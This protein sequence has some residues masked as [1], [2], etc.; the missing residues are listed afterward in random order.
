MTVKGQVRHAFPAY[1]V[2][3]FGVDVTED[4]LAVEVQ[5]NSGRAPNGCSITLAN[6]LDKYIFTTND[7]KALFGTPDVTEAIDRLS[8]IKQVGIDK[9]AVES[10]QRLSDEQSIH[11][12][13][14]EGTSVIQPEIKR[15]VINA[16]VKEKFI[17]VEQE[18][19][20]D[21]A[22][23]S[24]K[25]LIGDAPRYPFQA[26]DPIF[27]ANDPIRVFFKDPF[28]PRRWY[29]AFAGFISDFDDSVD[30]NNQATLTVSGEGPTKVFRY[31]RITTNPGIIDINA[32]AQAKLDAVFRS[33][34]VSGFKKLTLP[35]LLFAITFGNDP[36]NEFGGSFTVERASAE[37]T[38]VQAH[39]LR[40]VGNFN[41][42]RS[43]VVE[44]GNT[45]AGGATD[46]VSIPGNINTFSVGSLGEYQAII[47]HEV[48]ETDLTEMVGN[49]PKAE[50][51]ATLA[52]R[53]V[54]RRQ[55]ADGSPGEADPIA[56][57]EAIGKNPQ[58]YPVDGGRLIIL[59]PA[60]FQ[61]E[62]NREVLLKDII[63]AAP[64]QTEFKSRLGIIYDTIER[65]EF[66][67][68]ESPK[69][70]LICEFPLYDFDPQDFELEGTFEHIDTS[71]NPPV[72]N[73]NIRRG[74]F[75]NKLIVN[76]RD[77][78]DFSKGVTD[79]KVR[80]QV[81]AGHKLFQ[82]YS[83]EADSISVQS[84]SV[85]VLR[86]LVPLYGLRLEQVDPK[87][88]ISSPQAA[89]TYAHITLNKLNADA[90]SLGINAVPNVSVWPINRPLYFVRR[91][92]IGTLTSL[93]HRIVWGMNG[94]MD[95]RYNINY[96]R[97]WDGLVD[98][99]GDP[100]FTT[101]GGKPGRPLDYTT[102]FGLRSLASGTVTTPPGDPGAG[103]E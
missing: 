32:V 18:Q 51:F 47:D 78:I 103:S 58:F 64:M 99:S 30:A 77:T 66:Q 57:M 28:L 75:G 6:E 27:H 84:P 94:S 95:T 34:Y 87:G 8:L 7:L 74:P 81:T 56:I 36:N 33:F 52:A 35:E 54:P 79:E 19:I 2:Y 97:G 25:A 93:T 45:T 91:N 22:D 61:A 60:S 70:D 71:A 13:I 80:T 92:C 50:N 85:V 88:F 102:L 37:D 89:L 24:V 38:D 82:N 12:I 98:D 16:K 42:D 90:R 62:I 4:V 86:H 68:Y 44:F 5:Y 23:G 72:R 41:F 53:D 3:I 9:V 21:V 40:A 48:K 76:R 63:D 67:F 73:A 101:I 14:T 69:G 17:A 65:I 39:P 83:A 96:L 10:N 46:D 20:S 31:G 43:L 49:S 29:H 55:N 11:D 26:E 100:V 15:N 1:K 59:V